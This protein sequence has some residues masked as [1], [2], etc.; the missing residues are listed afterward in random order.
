MFL[1]E[2]NNRLVCWHLKLDTFNHDITHKKGTKNSN[3][4]ALSRIEIHPTETTEG[5]SD[6][7]IPFFYF[8]TEFTKN[9]KLRALLYVTDK[10]SIIAHVG[11][12]TTVQIKIVMKQKQQ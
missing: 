6:S 10:K 7:D 3:P 5:D 8:L 9:L 4:D 11:E 2:P 12:E 1:K